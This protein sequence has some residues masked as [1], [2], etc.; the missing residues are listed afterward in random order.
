[1]STKEGNALSIDS[2][3]GG[4]Y[5]CVPDDTTKIDKVTTGH[6]NEILIANADGGAA[7]SGKSIGSAA[8][9]ST[10]NSN[11]AA[12]EA[13]VKTYA[14]TVGANAI[15]TAASDATAKSNTAE[16]NAKAYADEIVKWTNW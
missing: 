11:T 9:S 10:P 16:Q 12:T 13:A 1:M 7:L 4:L 15:S 3:N 5:V 8:L 6:A 2:V 14:D